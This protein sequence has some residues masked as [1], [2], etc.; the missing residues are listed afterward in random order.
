MTL[1]KGLYQAGR[2][3]D[4][5]NLHE[6]NWML[7]K[8]IT[9]SLGKEKRQMVKCFFTMDL[10]ICKQKLPILLFWAPVQ[11][12]GNSFVR[13]KLLA[14][15]H[16]QSP[17]EASPQNA[18]LCV[19]NSFKSNTFVYLQ[20]FNLIIRA[21]FRI[22][23]I[24]R[25]PWTPNSGRDNRRGREK[26]AVRAYKKF[27]LSEL[28]Q[29]YCWV[30]CTTSGITKTVQKLEATYRKC[31]KTLPSIP[32]TFPARF[33]L[34]KLLLSWLLFSRWWCCCCCCRRIKSMPAYFIL[35]PT[36]AHKNKRICIREWNTPLH[37][38]SK[39]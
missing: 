22:T 14:K 5:R 28:W 17:K 9:S 32:A 11:S 3:F 2:P 19:G 31:P 13:I 15:L 23:N 4:S 38:H 25:A 27:K 39:E 10:Q 16:S 12:C 20:A 29:Q 1:S 36:Q 26:T 30:L 6:P 7:N 37:W 35:F 21:T 33:L 34:W 8:L 18:K 24:G